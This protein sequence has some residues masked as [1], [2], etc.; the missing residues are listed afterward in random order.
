MSQRLLKGGNPS[1]AYRRIRAPPGG[2]SEGGGAGRGQGGPARR[3]SAARRQLRQ[4][5]ARTQGTKGRSRNGAGVTTL[6]MGKTV[7]LPAS[8]TPQIKPCA[9]S[10]ARASGQ[11][12]EAGSVCRLWQAKISP[13][14]PTKRQRQGDEPEAGGPQG[15]AAARSAP[16]AP[17]HSGVSRPGRGACH[18]PPTKCPS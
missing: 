7:L 9:A 10:H 15:G 14:P 2:R 3:S 17:A 5:P 1:G 8:L 16:D 6:A 11:N 18:T 12:T 13:P 4:Q